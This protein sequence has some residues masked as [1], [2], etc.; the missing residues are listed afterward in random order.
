MDEKLE[1]MQFYLWEFCF[2]YLKCV[3][4]LLGSYHKA[5]ISLCI[6]KCLCVCIYLFFSHTVLSESLQPHELQHARLPSPSPSPRAC[7]NSC[8]LSQWCHPTILSSVAPSIPVLNLSQ[9]QDLFQCLSSSYQV[10]K[11]LELQHRSFPWI[12]RVDFL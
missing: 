4:L 7:S 12:F 5:F 6:H 1:R 10:A 2:L 9:H 8:P 3:L 11:V